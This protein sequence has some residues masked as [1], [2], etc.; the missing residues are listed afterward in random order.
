MNNGVNLPV[1]GVPDKLKDFL[2]SKKDIR[3]GIEVNP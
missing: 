2:T 3:E 1:Y